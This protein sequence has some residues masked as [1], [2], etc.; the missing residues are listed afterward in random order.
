MHTNHLSAPALAVAALLLLPLLSAHAASAYIPNIDR[1]R[2][3]YEQQCVQC[4]TPNI[5]SRPNKLPLTR[6]ELFGIIDEMR[7]ISNLGWT[8]DEIDDVMEYLNQTRYHFA[9]MRAD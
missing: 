2:M 3:L 6:S 1:G 4:H 7:R 8:P 5:H 9:P